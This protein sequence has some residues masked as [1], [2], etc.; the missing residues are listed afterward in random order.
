ML[1]QG[2]V[3]AVLLE[4]WLFLNFL[5]SWICMMHDIAYLH[6]AMHLDGEERLERTHLNYV[7]PSITLS[8]H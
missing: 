2:A 7:A 6:A 4:M 5:K 8:T 3:Q 1:L